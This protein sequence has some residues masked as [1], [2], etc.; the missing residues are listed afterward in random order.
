MSIRSGV[1]LMGGNEVGR[2][3]VWMSLLLLFL[4]LFLASSLFPGFSFSHAAPVCLNIL[5]SLN[6]FVHFCTQLLL[7]V[8][9]DFIKFF[10]LPLFFN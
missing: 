10:S 6:K 2:G 7:L 4:F 1:R 9:H 8:L 5:A 3:L